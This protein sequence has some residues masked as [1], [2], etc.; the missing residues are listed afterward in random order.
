MPDGRMQWDERSQADDK[1]A[2][3]EGMVRSVTCLPL[4]RL[5]VFRPLSPVLSKPFDGCH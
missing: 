4:L 5:G 2:P 1:P 3:G